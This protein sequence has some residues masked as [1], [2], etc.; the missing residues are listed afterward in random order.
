M[1]TAFYLAGALAVIATAMAITQRNAVHSLLY[2]IVSL[3]SIAVNL[4]LLG[5]P[6]V[7]ALEVIIYAGAIMV[8]ILFVVMML[9]IGEHATEVEMTWLKPRAWIWPGI[10][11]GV[12]LAEVAYLITR[13]GQVSLPSGVVGVKE[14]SIA[15]FGPYVIGVE[16]AS[17]L[18]MAGLVGAYHLGRRAVAR[19]EEMSG[20]STDGTRIAVGGDLVHAGS[21]R[22]PHAA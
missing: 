12:L 9:N 17:F 6:F 15:L 18:L 7:A 19:K 4:Y 11:G 8:L 2:L 20:T 16:L 21:D 10:L 3:L 22:T 13:T 1:N 14:V 5:A